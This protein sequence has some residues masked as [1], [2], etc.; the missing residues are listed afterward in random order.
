MEH[1]ASREETVSHK[2]A[3]TALWSGIEK[4]VSMGTQFLVTLILARLLLPEDYGSIAILTVFI[5]ISERMIE[6]GV[7]NAL[8]RKMDCNQVDYSTGFYFNLMM[9]LF[10]YCILF[11]IAPWVSDFYNIPILCNVLRIYG[12]LIIANALTLVQYSM[13]SKNL[14]FKKLA[15]IKSVSVILSG[16]IGVGCAY[17]GLGVWALVAQGLSSSVLYAFSMSLNTHWKPSFVFSRESFRYLWNFGSKML[18][19]GIIS[20]LY[21]NIYSL[22]IG[23]VYDGRSLG[24]FNRGQYTANLPT[25][26]LETVFIRSSLPIL[27]EFQNDGQRL[28]SVYR[29]FVI[30]VAFISFPICFLLAALAVPFVQ[31]I[32]TDRWIDCAI[33]IQIFAVSAVIAAPNI[34]NLNLFQVKGRSDI[35]LKAEIIKKSAGAF[36]V[37]LLLPF[38]PLILAIG[39]SV[40]S[41]FVY[42]IN[43]YYAKKLVGIP[44]ILQIRD[45]MP[46]CVSA[47]F[48]STAAYIFTIIK[49]PAFIHL[50][51]GGIIGCIIYYCFTKYIYKM[52]IYSQILILIKKKKEK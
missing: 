40:F 4:A 49:L 7:S 47:I 2:T 37:F 51:V 13:L 9:S 6:S 43:L 42:S 18:L 32:L 35:T 27:S 45:I 46:C 29:K 34:L 3:R 31:V 11:S 50:F 30:L 33:Y 1:D 23:K 19:T 17:Y 16:I 48:A 20:S 5:G 38:G 14:E 24:L 39:A 22:V 10:L 12:L 44:F 28:V 15:K 36:V 26:V 41:V 8:I 25:G 52:E 21:G